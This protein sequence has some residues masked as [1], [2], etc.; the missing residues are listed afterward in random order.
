MFKTV[1]LALHVRKPFPKVLFAKLR[2]RL[3]LTFAGLNIAGELAQFNNGSGLN[4]FLDLI[5]PLAGGLLG[6]QSE[7]SAASSEE[8]TC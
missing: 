6:P 3:V 7:G 1:P 4:Q 5:V 2:S 8:P